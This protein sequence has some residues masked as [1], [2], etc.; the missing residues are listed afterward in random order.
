MVYV[1]MRLKV[2]EGV[3]GKGSRNLPLNSRDGMLEDI[4]SSYG[5]SNCV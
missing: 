1:Y 5:G 3:R 2:M 4:F